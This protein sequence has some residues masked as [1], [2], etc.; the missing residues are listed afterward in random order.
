MGREEKRGWKG[1]VSLQW[2]GEAANWNLH[3]IVE[4]QVVSERFLLACW[5]PALDLS[6]VITLGPFKIPSVVLFCCGFF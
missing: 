4:G 3:W 1:N 2:W 6:L 5:Y